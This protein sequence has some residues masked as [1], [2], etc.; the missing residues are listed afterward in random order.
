MDPLFGYVPPNP[1]IL[2]AVSVA[3]TALIA[4]QLPFVIENPQRSRY[5]SWKVLATIGSI[6]LVSTCVAALFAL[7]AAYS[8]YRGMGKEITTGL[9]KYAQLLDIFVLGM[10][11]VY[12]IFPYPRWLVIDRKKRRRA[13]NETEGSGGDTTVDSPPSS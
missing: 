5:M 8:S 13:A 10:V 3:L 2:T 7:L 6:A 9:W 1:Y 11:F 12:A 4:A